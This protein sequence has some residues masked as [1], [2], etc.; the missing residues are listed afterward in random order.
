M[1]R[2]LLSVALGTTLAL[3]SCQFDDSDMWDKFG[4]MEESIRDHEQRISALEELCK[5]MNTNIEALQT[6][7]NALEKRDYVTNISEVRSNGEV[8]GYTISFGKSDT[9]TIYHGKDGKDGVNGA[10]GKDGYTPQIGIMKDTDNIY[11][12]TLDGDCLLDADGNKIK[13]VGTDGKDGQDGADGEDGKDG[14]NGS[15]GKNGQDAIA[16]QL[17]IENDYWY[18]SYDN[19]ATWV[20]LGKATGEDGKDGQDSFI[21]GV[22][23]SETEVVFILSNNTTITIPKHAKSSL[24]DPDDICTAM[25]DVKFM[26]YCYQNFDVN[27]DGKVSPVEAKSVRSIDISELKVYS[28]KGVEYFEILETL[29]AENTLLRNVDIS[30]NNRLTSF[31]FKNC[32]ALTS[33]VLPNNITTIVSN[34]FYGC[35]KL[36][37]VIIPDSVT[38]IGE[39]AFSNCTSLTSVTIPDSVTSIGEDTFSGCT[40]LTSVTIGKSVTSIGGGAFDGCSSLTSVIIPDSVTSIGSSAFNNCTALTSITIP[41]GVT[42]IGTYAFYGCRSLTSVIIPDSV[43]SIGNFAFHNCSSLKA[44]H[45]EFAS[46]DNRCLVI[47]G[48]LN[49]FAPA[50]LTEYTI[51][52]SVTSIGEYA[53]SNCTSL[54][55]VTIPDSVTSIGGSAFSHCTSLIS[56]TIGKSVTSIGDYAFWYCRSLTS[57]YCKP[58][59]PPTGSSAMFYDNASDRKI[60]VPRN[61]VSAYKAK[62]YWKDYASDIE[63]YDF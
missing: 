5:Q 35:N 53:F 6:L 14:E 39:Y 23:E 20:Q 63:G 24:A 52:N 1:K 10:D 37:S 27:K 8:I 26:E 25:D 19:G 7:V 30:F 60:Y 21:I 61:S 18:V 44:F 32:I 34:A 3:T 51:P 15:D 17:K 62:Q 56:V 16:P 36:G 58:T 57:V 47:D 59:T 55:S 42:S 12:W 22:E 13:A 43:T 2:F 49:S 46:A 48:V 4:E 50:G 31:S 29:K 11:Y 28:I 33:M 9:I 40:S 45:G 41:D 54:T 38:S